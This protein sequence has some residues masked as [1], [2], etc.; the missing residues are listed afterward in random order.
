MAKLYMGTTEVDANRTV[1]EIQKLLAI[2]GASAVMISYG[3]DKEPEGI[4]FQVQV[5]GGL[6]PTLFPADGRLFLKNF[7]KA[8]S[9]MMK[10][11]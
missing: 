2:H 7:R 1:A 9:G 11:S 5:P 8:G 3:P 10:G 4:A 6:S